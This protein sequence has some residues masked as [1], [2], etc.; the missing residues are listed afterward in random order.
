MST[1]LCKEETDLKLAFSSHGFPSIIDP[2]HFVLGYRPRP[3]CWRIFST[4]GEYV[5]LV[6]PAEKPWWLNHFQT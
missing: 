4:L 6:V 2:G 3:F 5:V 1:E